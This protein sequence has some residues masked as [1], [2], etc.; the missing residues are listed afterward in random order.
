MDEFGKKI[1]AILNE[2]PLEKR[3]E[4]R[5][6]QSRKIALER[7]KKN[8]FTEVNKTDNEVIS[9]KSKFGIFND[10]IKWFVWLVVGI[11]LLILQQAYIY[12]NAELVQNSSNNYIQSND[13]L[14]LEQDNLEQ[15]NL[16]EE[17]NNL[18]GQEDK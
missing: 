2:I 6:E 3:I 5:L 13:K 1:A 18:S 9:L 12:S 14:S 10:N 17:N 4:D 16:E 8:N 11:I 15:D 7:I